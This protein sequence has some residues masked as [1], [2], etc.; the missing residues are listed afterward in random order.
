ML[1]ISN[2]ATKAAVVVYFFARLLHFVVYPAGL[3]AARTHPALDLTKM[4]RPRRYTGRVTTRES[5]ICRVN[6]ST[7]TSRNAS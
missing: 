2:A 4:A 1:G 3:P 6:S 7:P 5:P